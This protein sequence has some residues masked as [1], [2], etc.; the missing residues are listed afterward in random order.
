MKEMY[1]GL[2]NSIFEYC[3]KIQQQGR[4]TQQ[5]QQ[6]GPY[7]QQKQQYTNER[8]KKEK[9]GSLFMISLKNPYL[10][11]N[12]DDGLWPDIRM[13]LTFSILSRHPFPDTAPASPIFIIF[14]GVSTLFQF[15]LCLFKHRNIRRLVADN[16]ERELV[17]SH[18]Y[19]YIHFP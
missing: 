1:D 7:H 18:N 14:Y 9:K 17:T 11:Y 3:F 2:W 5:Y 13:D 6:L 16:S 10:I 4:T 8:K 15:N 19:I 12:M